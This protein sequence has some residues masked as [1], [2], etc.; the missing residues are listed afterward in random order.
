M[1]IS[2]PMKLTAADSN[3]RTVTG[4]IVTWNEQGSTSAG[5]TVFKNNS[6][7]LG[8]NV[9]LLW[10]HRTEKP[11]GKLIAAEITDQGIEASFKIAG[12]LAGDDYLT[13][14]AEGLRDGLSVGV[15]VNAWSNEEGVMTI[16]SAQLLS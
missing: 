10:E 1:K 6:I 11:L 14:A 13:G 5:L 7:D 2:M 8:K 16:E 9:K 3:T 12:T 15:K 4:R